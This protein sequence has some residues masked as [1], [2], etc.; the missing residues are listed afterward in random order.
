MYCLCH[1]SNPTLH[2][3]VCVC[4]Q[5]I[6]TWGL[7]AS[8]CVLAVYVASL[9][10]SSPSLQYILKQYVLQQQKCQEPRNEATFSQHLYMRYTTGMRDQAFTTDSYDA[11]YKPTQHFRPHV[12]QE[13]LGSTQTHNCPHNNYHCMHWWALYSCD[14]PMRKL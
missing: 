8:Q 5:I 9:L 14:N 1:S 13:F 4:I 6:G 10:G 3:L 2:I 11:V 7:I 12:V